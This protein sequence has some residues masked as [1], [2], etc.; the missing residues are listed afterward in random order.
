M[1]G[2]GRDDECA[3]AALEEALVERNRLWEELHRRVAQDREVEYLRQL[4]AD[5]EASLSWRITKPLRAAKTA[6]GRGRELF[7]KALAVLGRDAPR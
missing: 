3:Q 5:L 7:A 4:N 6:Y 2:P 1:S